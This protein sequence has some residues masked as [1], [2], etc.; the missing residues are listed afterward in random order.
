MR[1]RRRVRVV[2]LIGVRK[3]A[4]GERRVLGGSE[5]AA[6][7]NARLPGAAQRLYVGDRLAAREKPRAGDHRGNGVEDVMLG[8]LDH[9]ARKLSRWRSSDVARQP[10]NHGM[11]PPPLT[12]IDWPVMYR[13]SGP[14]SMRTMAAISSGSPG[15]PRWLSIVP[16][17]TQLTV[18]FFGARSSASALVRPARPDFAAMTCARPVAP[19]WPVSPPMLMMVPPSFMCGIHA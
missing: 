10:F 19:R 11:Y 9:L 5:K 4:V 17:T 1:E 15:R 12:W 7:D 6:A 16:G 2:G 3:H 13:A 18:I 14:H 8:L